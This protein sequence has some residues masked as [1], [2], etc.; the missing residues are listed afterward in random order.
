MNSEPPSDPSQGQDERIDAEPPGHDAGGGHSAD[1][2]KRWWMSVAAIAGVL[3]LA[4]GV[5]AFLFFSS[6]PDTSPDTRDELTSPRQGLACPYLRLAAD[7]YERGD[8]PAVDRTIARAAKI[9]EDTLQE[10]GQV[11]GE[12]ERIAL[13]LELGADQQLPSLLGRVDSACSNVGQ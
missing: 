1:E 12:P 11:F 13:E 5:A 4:W 7:A 3:A 6:R 10:S 2:G 9:A 8:H